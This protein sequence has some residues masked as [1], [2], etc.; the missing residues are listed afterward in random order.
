[1]K[2]VVGDAKAQADGV[3]RV[4]LLLDMILDRHK[5]HGLA[6]IC[7]FAHGFKSGGGNDA[8]AGG[9]HFQEFISIEAVKGESGIVTLF[10]RRAR[11][12]VKAVEFQLRMGFM[13][14]NDLVG[15]TVV[16]QV[17][18]SEFAVGV[19]LQVEQ[20]LAEN[21][22]ADKEGFFWQVRR[23]VKRER[24]FSGSQA[25]ELNEPFQPGLLDAQTGGVNIIG[26]FQHELMGD[27][28]DGRAASP[29]GGI[30][31]GKRFEKVDDNVGF[32][33][34][35]HDVDFPQ[36]VAM[37]SGVPQR[38]TECAGKVDGAI[39][40]VNELDGGQNDE[41]HAHRRLKIFGERAF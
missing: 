27:D 38:G 21:R 6:K 23:F 13:P 3:E 20:L 41:R 15:I 17:N 18:Q 12:V 28:E 34:P 32:I 35:D 10:R 29:A 33:F 26:M 22:W 39:L 31:G 25:D 37:S 4:E 1:M 5:K 7:C 9:H 14:A 16:E 19:G 8:A 36:A 11:A 30:Q 2:G 40:C 24:E